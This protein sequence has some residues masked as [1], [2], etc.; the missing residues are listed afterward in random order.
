MTLNTD[1]NI[2]RSAG[3]GEST[4]FVVPFKFF[5]PEDLKV[6]VSDEDGNDGE[7][8]VLNTDYTVS[9]AGADDGGAVTFAVAP[10]AGRIVT[11]E[12]VVVPL[13]DADYVE[14]AGFPADAHERVMDRL[15]ASIQDMR[16][17]LLRTIYFPRSDNT[18]F[19]PLP[20]KEA[21]KGRALVFDPVTGAPAVSSDLYN[22]Q[23]TI[24]EAAAKVA[25]D[26]ADAAS[27]SAS[28]AND[29]AS[30]AADARDEAAAARDAA[31]NASP[32]FG[33]KAALEAHSFDTAPDYVRLAG[34]HE[35]GDGGAALY[36][37]TETEPVHPGK[38]QS[39]DGSWFR[40]DY[41]GEIHVSRFGARPGADPAENTVA[42]QKA[43]DFAAALGGGVIR[44]GPGEYEQGPVFITTSGIHIA[45]CGKSA[46]RIKLKDSPGENQYALFTFGR[47]GP[48]GA[49]PEISDAA[50]TDMSIDGNIAGQFNGT[51]PSDGINSG[52]LA[53]RVRR[54]LAAR[55]YIHHCDGYGL[56]LQGTNH[57]SRSD[58]LVEDVEIGWCNYDGIDFKGG[59]EHRPHRIYLNRV[60][61][62]NCGV[63]IG[64]I[65]G[66]GGVGTN[67]RGQYICIR[68]SYFINCRDGGV[69]CVPGENGTYQ[70]DLD[71]VWA[72]ACQGT[73]ISITAAG[74]DAADSPVFASLIN[75]KSLGNT[76]G[77]GI[78]DGATARL[79]GCYARYNTNHGLGASSGSATIDLINCSIERNGQDGI[80]YS[81]AATR[82][83]VIGGSISFNGR[84]GIDFDG[85]L[86][87]VTAAKVQS[88]GQTAT[89]VA[90]LLRGSDGLDWSFTDCDLS[91]KQDVPT[92]AHAVQFSSAPNA[93][94]LIGCDLRGNATGIFNGS[95]PAGTEV[96]GC[97]GYVTQSKG[98]AQIESGNTSVVV[99][100]GL[101]A[102]PSPGD[103]LLT[104]ASAWGS[105][106]KCWVSNVGTVEFTI[107]V[108]AD[109]GATVSFN[110]WARIRGAA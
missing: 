101:A 37:L 81:G 96:E 86:L 24:A 25:L 50:I 30:S 55:L 106:A 20:G 67:P 83:T 70:I 65:P 29:A 18:P 91:D 92:Q 11:R 54:F 10:P 46:T 39:A 34:Y 52:V 53:Y 19:D 21:R 75:C 14:H 74:A 72:I 35:A 2:A 41:T 23:A 33:S 16:A 48:S 7:P 76:R 87:R 90:A 3:D 78:E 97:S 77:F 100:H 79:T 103:I 58:F 26:A 68:D 89:G 13:Q 59:A 49:T 98:V 62:H 43:I 102:T 56:G 88:N 47:E 51:D 107:N 71:N 31:L 17:T 109:P 6:F 69:I 61:V 84:R 85:A 27:D 64:E 1:T 63:G 42:V 66:R 22:D 5:R 99:A 108:D 110:W 93:G 80:N 95:I 12:R 32:F 9:G 15:T 4:E 38:V 8:L 44:Y 94:R 73:G 104:V 28:A 60:V 82:L 36:F 57:P 45:G 40:L 105:A